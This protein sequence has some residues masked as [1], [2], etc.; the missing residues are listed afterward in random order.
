MDQ[1]PYITSGGC[2]RVVDILENI[3]SDAE[4]RAATDTPRRREGGSLFRRPASFT[5]F[6]P[7]AG[8][9]QEQ[10]DAASVAASIE[11]LADALGGQSAGEEP[12]ERRITA[13][14]VQKKEGDIYNIAGSDDDEQID[15]MSND[16]IGIIANYF[17]VG[18][19]IGG[20]TS[21]LYP[22]LIVKAGATASLMTASYAVVMVFWS[23][24]IVFGFLS[25]CF[26]I[27]G[28]KRK[29]YIVIGVSSFVNILAVWLQSSNSLVLFDI[30][31]LFC[32]GVLLSLAKV[33]SFV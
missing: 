20:T 3:P 19:M 1:N 10:S 29:P 27:F 18:L 7:R 15:P 2:E 32:A 31:W 12:E 4:R 26:P 22:I 9:S 33:S 24:K 28:Y 11:S 8:A 21:I 14:D 6:R 30:Q 17:S 23:Y 5:I 13:L 25:D 16:Y